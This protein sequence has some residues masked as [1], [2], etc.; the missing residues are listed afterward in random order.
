MIALATTTNVR[1]KFSLS[2]V[3]AKSLS[4][5]ASSTVTVMVAVPLW[6]ATGVKDNEPVESPLV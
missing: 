2:A 3:V 4:S 6:F 1:I 5:P